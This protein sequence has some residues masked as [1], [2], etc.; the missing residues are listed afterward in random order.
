MAGQQTIPQDPLANIKGLEYQGTWDANINDPPLASGVGTK[1]HYYVVS[2]AGNTN[3]DGEADWGVGDFVIFNG[4]TWQKIDGSDAVTAVFTRKGAVVAQAGDYT[5][6]QIAGVGSDDH[7]AKSH[8][9]DG[10]DGSGQVTHAHTTG[11]TENDHHAKSHAHDGVDGSGTVA[12]SATTGKTE[13]DHHNRQHALSSALDHTGAITDTQHG[14]RAGGST[15]PLVTP[16]PGGVAGFVDPA[17]KKKLNDLNVTN[18]V[19]ILQWFQ[20]LPQPASSGTPVNADSTS[21]AYEAKARFLFN[22]ARLNIQGTTLSGNMYVRARITGGGSPNGDIRVY[23]VTDGQ[24]L[25][26][27]NFTEGAFTTKTQALA[28]IPTTGVKVVEIQ[29]R[30]NVVGSTLACEAASCDFVLTS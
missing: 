23:N 18:Q 5:H 16:D 17:D 3:L 27:I 20:L 11:Q 13:N 26:V 19:Q 12:H 21:A 25:G 6:A 1:N 22:F 2:V 8:A 9:H 4:T 28:N 24:Q 15:H 30:R 14:S 10:L 29:M 7:H